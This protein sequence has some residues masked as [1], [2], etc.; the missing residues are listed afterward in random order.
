[1]NILLIT[2]LKDNEITKEIYQRKLLDIQYSKYE[3]KILDLA[4]NLQR[5]Q[6]I[7]GI[8]SFYYLIV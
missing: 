1:M 8:Q 4:S 6:E 5:K 3:E 2:L 7:K